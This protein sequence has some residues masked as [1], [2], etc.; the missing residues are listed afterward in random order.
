[1][2]I[3]FYVRGDPVGMPRPRFARSGHAYTP[4]GPIDVWKAAIASECRHHRPRVPLT[5]PVECNLRFIFRR[6]KAHFTSKGLRMNAPVHH[7]VKPDKDNL[8]KAV[9]DVLTRNGFWLDDSQVARGYTAK[10][11]SDVLEDS[12][13]VLISISSL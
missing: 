5:G 1:M 4:K 3:S 12:A 10:S 13:G 8:E 7:S 11:Y 9:L 6:P 2:N